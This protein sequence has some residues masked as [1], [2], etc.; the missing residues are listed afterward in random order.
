[1]LILILVCEA[2]YVSCWIGMIHVYKLKLVVSSG[3]CNSGNSLSSDTTYK[4]VLHRSLPHW[5]LPGICLMIIFYCHRILGIE[6]FIC[7][8]CLSFNCLPSTTVFGWYI[9]NLMLLYL[10]KKIWLNSCKSGGLLCILAVK[11]NY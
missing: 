6:V 2:V 1:M 10:C 4:S 11:C 8:F 9:K 7:G 5:W 3:A